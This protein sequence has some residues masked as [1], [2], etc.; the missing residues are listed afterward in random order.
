MR[1]TGWGQRLVLLAWP[2]FLAAC[3]LELV[4]FA[5]VDPLDLQ[6]SGAPL[7]WSRQ[8]VYTGAFFVFWA[9]AFAAC[10]LTTLLRMT[11]AEVNE[12]PFAPEDRPEGCPGR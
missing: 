6:W 12:C 8:G 10:V 5:F 2:A 7:D 3:L 4:V 1:R 9:I 11:P